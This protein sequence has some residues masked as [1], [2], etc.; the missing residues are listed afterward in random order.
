MK[1]RRSYKERSIR[2]SRKQ[3]RELESVLEAPDTSRRERVRAQVLLLS[4]TGW[5]REDIVVA[6]RTSVSTVGRVRRNFCEEGLE[7]ALTEKP[8]PGGERKLTVREEQRIVALACTG[9]PEGYTR[10]TVR[11]LCAESVRRKLIPP[12]SR[13]KIRIVLRDHDT[14]PWREKNVVYSRTDR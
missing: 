13:E 8:R 1:Q 10:W 14:K 3:R 4:A 9:P 2:L 12:V 6:A 5:D 11:L 7:A